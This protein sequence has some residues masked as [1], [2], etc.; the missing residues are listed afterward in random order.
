MAPLA[1][2]VYQLS[3]SDSVILTLYV[4]GL[5]NLVGQLV[6]NNLN[7]S[8]LFVYPPTHRHDRVIQ[9]ATSGCNGI[10]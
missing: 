8:M 7:F 1:H 4:V 10:T 2:A 6:F 3:G 9:C 5:D